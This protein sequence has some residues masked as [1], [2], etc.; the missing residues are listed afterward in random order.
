M[1]ALP[2]HPSQRVEEQ[3]EEYSLISF[4]LAPTNEFYRRILS[5][6]EHMEIVSPPEVRSEFAAILDR[7]LQPYY[8]EWS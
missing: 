3:G 2:L 7:M 8:E 4:F 1:E 5:H 6:R